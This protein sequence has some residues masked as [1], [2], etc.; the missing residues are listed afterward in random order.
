MCGG[1]HAC[2]SQNMLA[3]GGLEQCNWC[4]KVRTVEQ[5]KAWSQVTGAAKRDVSTLR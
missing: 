4:S 5:V 2:G 1:A 3:G